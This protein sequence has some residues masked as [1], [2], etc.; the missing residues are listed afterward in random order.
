MLGL[1]DVPINL[2]GVLGWV[3]IGYVT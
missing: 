1:G 3:T 2:E